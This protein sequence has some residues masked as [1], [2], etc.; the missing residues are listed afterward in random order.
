VY[1]NKFITPN[2]GVVYGGLNQAIGQD[3]YPLQGTAFN[4]TVL[5]RF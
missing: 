3:A 2:G 5:R 4:V 1:D